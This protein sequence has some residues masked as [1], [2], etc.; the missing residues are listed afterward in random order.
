MNSNTNKRRARMLSAFIAVAL[1]IALLPAA[2][3]ALS[4]SDISDRYL[5][6]CVTNASAKGYSSPSTS[7]TVVVTIPSGT[8]LQYLG[9]STQSE[10]MFIY[11]QYNGSFVFVQSSKLTPTAT[12]PAPIAQ[13]N[14]YVP[15]A[16]SSP[17][18]MPDGVYYPVPDG[19]GSYWRPSTPNYPGYYYGAYLVYDSVIQLL[20]GYATIPSNHYTMFIPDNSRPKYDQSAK[21]IS[22][23]GYKTKDVVR[24]TQQP[25]G[26]V[27]RVWTIDSNGRVTEES[28]IPEGSFVRLTS[29]GCDHLTQKCPF[30][31]LARYR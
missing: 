4:W 8:K 25:I 19:S 12:S 27:N 31:Y 22:G 2:A 1:C 5:V 23:F 26:Y 17:L 13:V 18:V 6:P 16:P 21:L 3:F 24:F 10:G 15:P 7:S 14:P 30:N 28:S 9:S 29:S 11:V 20:G